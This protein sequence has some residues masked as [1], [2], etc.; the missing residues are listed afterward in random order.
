[1]QVGRVTNPYTT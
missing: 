1:L